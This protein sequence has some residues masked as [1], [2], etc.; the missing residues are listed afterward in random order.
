MCEILPKMR[1]ICYLLVT[2]LKILQLLG[3][4]PGPPTGALPLD[5]AGDS[6]PQTPVVL[7]PSQTSL[8]RQ[9]FSNSLHSCRECGF[10]LSIIIIII[11]IICGLTT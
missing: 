9:C 3:D 10:E 11:I 8:R 1:K 6:V 4:F 7:P 5:P 2:T